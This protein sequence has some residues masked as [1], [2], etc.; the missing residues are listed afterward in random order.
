MEGVYFLD[1]RSFYDPMIVSN[2]ITTA[3]TSGDGRGSP[4][5]IRCCFPEQDPSDNSSP[6]FNEAIS[7]GNRS[8]DVEGSVLKSSL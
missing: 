4:P 2:G 6:V 1:D 3:A 8:S 5:Q 7:S